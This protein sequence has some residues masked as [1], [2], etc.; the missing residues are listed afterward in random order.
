MHVRAQGKL[1]WLVHGPGRSCS[2]EPDASRGSAVGTPV[3]TPEKMLMN[4]P[5]LEP[6]QCP[7]KCKRS[8]LLALGQMKPGFKGA[9]PLLFCFVS[10][11]EVNR[12]CSIQVREGCFHCILLV[13]ISFVSAL[14]FIG[15]S[16]A[17]AN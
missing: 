8:C 11:D 4:I 16:P 12:L 3:L 5:M 2:E 10:L 6:Y 15:E 9:N 7:Y 17:T 14:D 1:G 13:S